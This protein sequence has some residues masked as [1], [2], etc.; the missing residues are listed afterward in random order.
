MDQLISEYHI[1]RQVI[2]DVLEKDKPLNPVEREV[3]V[4]SIEQ[5]VNDAASEFSATL[6]DLKDQMT[7]I[8]AHDLRNPL[9]TAKISTQLI[10]RTRARSFLKKIEE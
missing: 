4:C 8:L 6:K 5:A 2:C 7:Q 3:I 9:T 1:L 10:M